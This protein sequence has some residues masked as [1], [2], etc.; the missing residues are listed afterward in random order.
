LADQPLMSNVLADLAIE[1]EAALLLALDLAGTFDEGASAHAQA[2]ARL[3]VPA[4]KYW[5]CKR[6]PVVALEAMEVL[7][8]NGYV[9]EQPLSRLSRDTTAKCIWRG[10]R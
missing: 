5:V 2:L 8:G 1:T 9:E 7:G 4:A 10:S 6:A 3:L